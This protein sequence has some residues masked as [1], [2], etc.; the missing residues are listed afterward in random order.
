VTWPQEVVPATLLPEA[1]ALALA[2]GWLTV[3]HEEVGERSGQT[4]AKV[5]GKEEA[6]ISNPPFKRCVNR[7]WCLDWPNAGVAPRA[8]RIMP[9]SSHPADGAG[10]RVIRL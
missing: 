9:V 6:A 5:E 2:K 7:G 3:A 10:Q 1:T 4:E 8:R